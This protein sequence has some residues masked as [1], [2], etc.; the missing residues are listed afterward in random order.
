MRLS[1]N[2]RDC[3]YLNWAIPLDAAPTLPREL[4]YEVHRW[5]DQDWVFVTALLFRFIGLHA[6]ALPFFRLS[7]PQMNLRIYVQ[8]VSGARSVLYVRTLVPFWVLPMSRVAGRQ[9]ASAG[10]FNYPSPSDDPEVGGWSW[11][12]RNRH[13]L[14]VTAKIA[15]PLLGEGP[16]LGGWART[17]EYFQQRRKGYAMW[18]DR[19]RSVNKSRATPEVWPLAAEVQTA[20]VLAEAFPTLAPDH[21]SVPHSSWLCPEI[22]FQFEVG[23]PRLMSLPSRH[24][25]VA[26]V[27]DC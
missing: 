6:R 25:M 7:Y 11:S 2:A 26:A 1:T 17:I 9:P 19:L 13:A 23:K 22:P 16:D 10:R 8:D 24:R 3:L 4:S 15:A 5:R 20:E 12:L 18:E 27:S 21:W 14:E